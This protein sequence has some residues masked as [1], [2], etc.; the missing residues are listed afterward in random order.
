MRKRAPNPRVDTFSRD[1]TEDKPGV[2]GQSRGGGGGGGDDSQPFM[3]TKHLSFGA[4]K[5]VINVDL[6]R[7]Q[8]IL[9]SWH[10]QRLTSLHA[11]ID[12]ILQ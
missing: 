1:E 4:S 12:N 11:D 3:R 9:S 8:M 2:I 5:S 6:S 7:V 10:S